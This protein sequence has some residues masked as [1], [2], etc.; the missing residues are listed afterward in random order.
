M[1]KERAVDK[2]AERCVINT[3]F[4]ESVYIVT[5]EEKLFDLNIYTLPLVIDPGVVS[6][7]FF[8]F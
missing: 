2:E 4:Q 6:I 3:T 5:Q 1:V 8:K 7:A